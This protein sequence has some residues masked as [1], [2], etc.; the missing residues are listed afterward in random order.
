MDFEMYINNM[1]KPSD[2][3]PTG[4]TKEL[5]LEIIEKSVEAYNQD[6]LEERVKKHENSTIED[7]Q[8]F[9][10][11]TCAI[12]ALI[13]NGRKL[14]YYEL[15]QRMMD[16]C[17]RDS[18]KIKG[19]SMLDFSIKEIMLA[20]KLMQDKVPED[21]RIYWLEELRKVDP[22]YNYYYTYDKVP[23]L[24]NINIYNMAGEYLRETEG[25]TSTEDYFD[26]HWP[27]QL[28]K[29]DC[30]G[31]YIDPGSP[32]LYDVATRVQIQ[33]ILGFGYKGKYFDELDSKL[34]K[35]GLFTLFSQS[36]VFQLPYGGRSNQYQFNEALIAA[37]A[38]YEAQRYKKLGDFKTAGAFKRC[39]RLAAKSILPWLEGFKPPKHIKNYYPIESK[40]G[41]EEYGYYDKYM[42]TLGCFIYAAFLF[43]DDSIEEYPCPAEIGGFVFET[44]S[45]FHKIFANC[46]G[47][48]L[49]IDTKADFHD[50]ST[51]LGRCHKTGFPSELA[52][53]HPFTSK[54][55]YFLPKSVTK[56][57]ISFCAGWEYKGKTLYLCELSDGLEHEINMNF[58]TNERICFAITYY[59]HALKGCSAVKETYTLSAEGMRIE[60]Q[61]ID[62]DCPRIHYM[63]P[64]FIDNGLQEAVID[65]TTTSVSIKLSQYNLFIETNGS[66]QIS[67]EQYGNRNGKYKLAE[68][69]SKNQS[70]NILL[71]WRDEL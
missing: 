10:R 39:A 6:D 14:H 51:G 28:E 61:I 50:D 23:N 17:C 5:Y 65:S 2:F 24:H 19:N 35:G 11:L 59:G 38:E 55:S 54:P 43:A 29:F 48:S 32:I 31:M 47:S 53:S 16:I 20:F 40:Y 68:V 42:I 62:P 52:L 18:N 27:I 60:T 56:R 71:K 44:S 21:K 70:I 12:A 37:N 3:M 57:N 34:K 63:L 66:L 41:T 45:T 25:L 64:L 7:I 33:Y 9:S 49:E 69:I 8:A 46:C 13:A 67:K 4:S 36:S 22:Y 15:W 58:I 26:K 1:K 30:D